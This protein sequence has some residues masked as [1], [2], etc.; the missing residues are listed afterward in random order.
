LPIRDTED[1]R[2]LATAM[3]QKSSEYV[4]SELIELARE[5][6]LFE[7]IIGTQDDEI[8]RREKA[9]LP[10]SRRNR[11]R[12]KT[13]THP[14]FWSLVNWFLL[15]TKSHFQTCHLQLDQHRHQE[16]NYNQPK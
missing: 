1:M 7:R 4:F 6:G 12:R 8:G 16:P 15:L 13:E 3:E 2:P 11:C 14:S 5:H 9:A 10:R